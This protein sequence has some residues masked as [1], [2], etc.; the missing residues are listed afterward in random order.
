ML[1]FMTASDINE[2]DKKIEELLSV[3]AKG[4]MSALGGLYELI[5]ADIYAFALSKLRRGDEAED[6]THDTF[7]KIWQYAPAYKPQGKPMAWIL[8]IEHNLIRRSA[9]RS[10]R[11]VLS[12]EIYENEESGDFSEDMALNEFLKELMNTLSAEEQQVITLHVLSGL[13]HKEIARLLDT[14]LSTVLSRYSRAIKKLQKL[15]KGEL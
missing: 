7:V 2:R 3:L 14:P 13:K 11:T 5:R 6:I 8:T 15:G 12:E 1:L 10:A 4:D 9:K